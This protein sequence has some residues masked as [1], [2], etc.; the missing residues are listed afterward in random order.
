MAPD[1]YT[2]ALDKALSDLE[3]NIQR[4]ELLT[5]E[6]AGLRATVRVLSTLVPLDS[7]K[8]RQVA[9]ALAM[10]DYATPNL[11]DAIRSLLTKVH[12][13][14]MTAIEV[15]NELEDSSNMDDSNISLSACHAALKR[16][17]ADEEVEAG[18]TKE[19]KASYRRVLPIPEYRRLA[20]LAALDPN[21]LPK[22]LRDF[23]PS[24][25]LPRHSIIGEK[26]RK[27][28]G[29]RIGESKPKFYG[30]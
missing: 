24:E 10:A 19:G 8:Q 15:R 18:P 6:I 5:A 7:D 17:L 21:K 13:E 2:Q 20:S 26:P 23:H 4:R 14:E 22:E 12:P 11:T 3:K 16:M 30:K 1:E 25:P 9:Q 29:Q 28:L 27:T